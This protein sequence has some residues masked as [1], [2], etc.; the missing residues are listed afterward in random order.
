MK[1][2]RLANQLCPKSVLNV[3]TCL[4]RQAHEALSQAQMLTRGNMLS[5]VAGIATFVVPALFV[6]AVLYWTIRLGVKH[7]LR[8]YYAEKNRDSKAAS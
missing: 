5:I 1:T 4:G 8:S 6:A 7:G 2:A 3:L